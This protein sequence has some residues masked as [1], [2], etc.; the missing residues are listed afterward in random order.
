[1]AFFSPLI[2]WALFASFIPVLIHLINKRRHKSIQW[3]AIDFIIKATRERKGRKKLTHYLILLLRT[4][5][6]MALVLAIAR[7]LFSNFIGWN[8]SKIKEV[9]LILDRSSSMAVQANTATSHQDLLPEIIRNTMSAMGNPK[10][11]L[12]DSVTKRPTF[13]ASTDSLKELSITQTTDTA[14]DFPTLFNKTIQYLESSSS[15]NAEIWIASDMQAS[16]WQ[17]DSPKWKSIKNDLLALPHT[18]AIRFI[19]L[20]QRAQNNRNVN[21]ERITSDDSGITI[22]FTIFREGNRTSIE[23]TIPVTISVENSPVTFDLT[24]S[25]EKNRFARHFPL[26]KDK[27][28]G[29]GYISIP[30]DSRPSDDQAF[31]VFSPPKAADITI[32]AES[33]P[34]GA[35]LATM[36]AP[37][38]MKDRNS[39]IINKRELNNLNNCSLLIWQGELPDATQAELV[40]EYINNGGTALFFPPSV[41]SSENNELIGFK[42][43]AW[44]HAEQEDFFTINSWNHNRGPLRDSAENYP[45]PAHTVQAIKKASC[46]GHYSDIAQWND[47]TPALAKIQQGKGTAFF[48]SVLPDYSWSNLADGHLLIPLLQRLIDEGNTSLNNKASLITGDIDIPGTPD[49]V[50]RKIDLLDRDLSSQKQASPY[51][52]AGVYALDADIFCVN[53][54]REEDDTD[55]IGDDE[56]KHLFDGMKI[57]N[58]HTEDTRSLVEEGWRLFLILSILFLLGE[59]LLSMPAAEEKIN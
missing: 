32:V 52:T 45:M 34:I 20:R 42:W 5:A 38:G 28:K 49:T 41:E 8:S 24:L 51:T 7:P 54:P 40:G 57:S 36:S 26:P 12:I 22:D 55:Q 31:F 3:A 9:V 23:E 2:L 44:Q 14:S 17:E 56:L 1:M 43:G 29:Y 15:A 18:P 25:R 53:R 4:L 39:K 59:A 33:P 48:L 47:K 35:L 6:I 21:I 11:T 58:F 46:L 50:Y 27:T 16:D 13:I 19:S 10:L 30:H 37:A